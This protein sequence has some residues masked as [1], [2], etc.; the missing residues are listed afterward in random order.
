MEPVIKSVCE[1]RHAHIDERCEIHK[2][3]ID[4]LQKKV[5][6]LLKMQTRIQWLLISALIG[7]GVDIIRGMYVLDTVQRTYQNV[8]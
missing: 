7:L 4:A 6:C 5:N 2:E 1:E 3:E 8:K